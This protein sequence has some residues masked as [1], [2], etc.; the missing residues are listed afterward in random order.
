MYEHIHI[1]TIIKWILMMVGGSC[2]MVRELCYWWGYWVYEIKFK[3]IDFN[4][5]KIYNYSSIH[6]IWFTNILVL[7]IICSA[8][9]PTEK[10]QP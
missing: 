8:E 10:S 5:N 3:T 4:L 1:Y 9:E 2:C 7:S 6:F